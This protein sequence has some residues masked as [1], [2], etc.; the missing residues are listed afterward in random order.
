MDNTKHK[1]AQEIE[2]CKNCTKIKCNAIDSE[3]MNPN[4]T[5]YKFEPKTHAGN[6]HDETD[7]FQKGGLDE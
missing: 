3:C 6:I 2:Q 4:Q 5:Y 1:T 7:V